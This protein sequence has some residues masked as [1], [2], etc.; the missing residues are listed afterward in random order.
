MGYLAIRPLLELTTTRRV[1]L[2]DKYRHRATDVYLRLVSK[3]DYIP[4]IGYK[5]RNNHSKVIVDQIVQTTKTT[6][7]EDK[8]SDEDKLDALN[9]HDKLGHTKM[10]QK[11]AKLN[12][13]MNECTSYRAKDMHHYSQ[14]RDQLKRF[15]NDVDTNLFNYDT[16]YSV[17]TKVDDEERKRDLV[18]DTRNEIRGIKGLYMSGKA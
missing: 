10:Q 7:T 16:L 5:D 9:K 12:S 8:L 3:V 13:L 6:F 14:I 11:L 2:L 4:I 1:E 15:Q 18:V 17:S